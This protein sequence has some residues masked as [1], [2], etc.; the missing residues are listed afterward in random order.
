MG[1]QLV[2]P[3]TVA[4]TIL[5][6]PDAVRYSAV[7]LL[8]YANDAL[9][10]IVG[11]VPELF[12]TDGTH[13]CTAGVDQTLT[14]NTA[15]SLYNVNR[16][17]GGDVVAKCDLTILDTFDP[18]WRSA[19]SGAAKNWAMKHLNPLKFMV[20]PPAPV[21]QVLEISYVKVPS[22]YALTEDTG[23]PANLADAISDYVIYRAES[24]DDEHVNS[25]RAAQF[26]ASFVKKVKG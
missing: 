8:Q 10:Q 13:T 7:D 20:Y 18:A 9:D 11:L 15:I 5:N 3:V 26:M 22:E 21:N 19:A 12:V 25:E 2:S 1:L 17:Q 23:L 4:R 24:R 6:D 14:H 16:V